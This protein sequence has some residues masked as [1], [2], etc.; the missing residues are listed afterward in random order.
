MKRF[1]RFSLI[2]CLLTSILIFSACSNKNYL[3]V[4]SADYVNMDKLVAAEFD[5]EDIKSKIYTDY[6][7]CG[8]DCVV[9]VSKVFVNGDDLHKTLVIKAR[10]Q[11]NVKMVGITNGHIVGFDQGESASG[12]IFYPSSGRRTQLYQAPLQLLDDRCVGLFEVAGEKSV[13]AITSWNYYSDP[14][15]APMTLYKISYVGTTG[16]TEEPIKVDEVCSVSEENAKVAM[17]TD[18]NIIFVAGQTAM[19]SITLDGNI[20][21]IDVPEAWKYLIINSMVELEGYIY[22]GTHCGVIRY[23]PT[24]N[25]FTWFPVEYE[26][27]I[28]K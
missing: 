25:E 13:Y 3:S 2:L 23:S 21:K 28:P 24:S 12:I 15:P 16:E 8:Y 26:N 1:N 22:I 7:Y 6:E 14:A 19:Y 20:T 10:Q 18:S 5:I 27:V 11:T 9:S 4:Y 17:I